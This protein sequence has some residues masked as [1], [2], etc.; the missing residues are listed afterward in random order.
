[1]RL[2]ILLFPVPIKVSPSILDGGLFF[3]TSTETSER[4]RGCLDR[5]K[6]TIITF[7]VFFFYV[8]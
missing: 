3:Q 2:L 4:L 1:M 7:S 6:M 8:C 5:P